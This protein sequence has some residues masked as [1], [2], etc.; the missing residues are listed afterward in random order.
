ML[1]YI[2]MPFEKLH[3][4]ASHIALQGSQSILTFRL[5]LYAR[6]LPQPCANTFRSSIFWFHPLNNRILVIGSSNGTQL[7]VFNSLI[8]VSN[9]ELGIKK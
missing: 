9:V 2:T 6:R 8:R 5:A 4:A 3:Y 7:A 1:S